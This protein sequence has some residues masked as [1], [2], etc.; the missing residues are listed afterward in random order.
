MRFFEDTSVQIPI[1]IFSLK[2]ERSRG[3]RFVTANRAFLEILD[4]ASAQMDEL[5][6]A[7]VSLIHPEDFSSFKATFFDATA[8]HESVTWEGCLRI[9]ET[10]KS[11]RI[12]LCP[13]G[14]DLEN[15]LWN[16][17]LLDMTNVSALTARFQ[18]V[19]KAAQG[20][21]WRR[22]ITTSLSKSALSEP[23]VAQVDPLQT[24]APIDDWRPMVHPNDLPQIDAAIRA[25]ECGDVKHQTLAYRR[26][27]EDGS[28]SWWRLHAGIS[29]RSSDGTPIALAGVSFDVTAEMEE[30]GRSLL[31]HRE[32]LEELDETRAALERTAYD[33][34]ENIPI[35]TYTMVL[36]PN[37]ELA[38]FRFMSRK[39][40]EI[41]GLSADEARA[42]PLKAFACVHPDEFDTWVQKNAHAFVNR[43]P[44]REE[45]RLL[46]NG[47]TSWIVAESTPRLKEDGTWIWEGVI[48]D[49]TRQKQA[50]QALQ[51][52]NAQLTASE[53]LN[54]RLE[55]RQRLLQDIHDGFGNQLAI[56]K[57]RLN[58][59]VA[60]SS[61][62]AKIIEE[63]LDDLRLIFASL[64]AQGN[65]LSS[66]LLQVLEQLN[67]RMRH[68]PI[69]FMWD[70]DA[71]KQISM[72]P[73]ALLQ[74]ARIVQEAVANSVRHANA[75]SLSVTFNV[76]NNESWF[77][78]RDDGCGFDAER[79]TPGRGLQNM[80]LRAEQ[81]GWEFYLETSDAGTCVKL[82]IR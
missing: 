9:N 50:E 74:A 64:D 66:V 82:C 71:A 3:L 13:C 31:Q 70:I 29:E 80:R 61:D 20:H 11:V 58:R 15:P 30:R 73:R 28:W 40:L 21:I 52:A 38:K 34:T 60:S 45:T 65:S 5:A 32:I 14:I 16:G 62:A 68:L 54:A 17:V 6:T 19:L 76:E 24:I 77:A 75:Q 12:E 48:Q 27:L 46:V 47:K 41:T 4:C 37:E 69:S 55:E 39:F 57:L 23:K 42:D 36:K 67:K 10:L 33:L 26:M 49:I 22:D 44:F 53:V 59:G 78:I 18:S 8:S 72:E 43:I 7:L 51:E 25:L 79:I 81:Q 63:C 35:G 56:G 1:G 2:I